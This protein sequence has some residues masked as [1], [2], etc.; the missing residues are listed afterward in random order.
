MN[1]I[2]KTPDGPLSIYFSLHYIYLSILSYYL[3]FFYLSCCLFL[4]IYLSLYSLS[5][6]FYK[7]FFQYIYLSLHYIY[8]VEY[9][10]GMCEPWGQ[11]GLS[12]FN[13]SRGFLHTFIYLK[14]NQP[15]HYLSTYLF[16]NES[17][18]IQIALS[19]FLIHYLYD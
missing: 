9:T 18:Y 16:L 19:N 10:G 4:L 7:S 11:T 8:T 14:S 13:N 3:S 12:K 17:I 5:V 1:T 15:I 6:S 2:E